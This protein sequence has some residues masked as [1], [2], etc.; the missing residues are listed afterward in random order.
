MKAL[1]LRLF[2]AKVSNRGVDMCITIP[3]SVVEVIQGDVCVLKVEMAG[4]VRSVVSM[5]DNP[6][7]GD[8]VLV[9]SGTAVQKLSAEQVAE[10]SDMWKVIM[11]ELQGLED[12]SDGELK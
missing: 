5:V 8:Y 11:G 4:V 2:I 10:I 12:S 6:R 9:N 1:L 3:G 7:V